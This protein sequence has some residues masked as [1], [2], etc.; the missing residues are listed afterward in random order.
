MAPLT[1][2]F[3]AYVHVPY[4]RRICPYCDF[5]VH[6]AKRADWPGLTG[7]I[8][9]EIARRAPAFAASRAVSLY[10]GGGTPSLAPLELFARVRAVVEAHWPLVPDAEVSVEVDPATLGAAGFVALRRAGVTRLS[11]GWQSTHDRLL[12]VLGRGHSAADSEEAYRLARAAGHDDVSV[13]LI[14][15]VP[16]ETLADLDRDLDAILRLEPDHVSLYALTYHEGTEL[17]RRRRQGRLVPVDEELEAEMMIRVEARLGAAGYE[18]YEVS[19]YARPGK[20]SRHNQ[21]YWQGGEYAGLGPGAH[22]FAREGWRRGWRWE[23]VRAPGAYI[24]AWSQPGPAG[25]PA[26]GDASVSFVEELGPRELLAERFLVGLRLADGV[27]LDELELGDEAARI[28]H[29]AAEAAARGWIRRAGA[30]LVPTSAGLMR[31][32]ALAE[33]FF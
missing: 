19:N 17:H 6:I 20:R 12:R 11:L 10:F 14:F 9:A 31:A 21:I 7:A 32:D 16:G 24:A 18:H 26:A 30:R 15:G 1:D 2:S 25:R 29:A 8:E 23:A 27:S 28:E 5:N 13:D 4:C 3:G 22:S 33:L